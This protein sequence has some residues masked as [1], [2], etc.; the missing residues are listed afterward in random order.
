M[1]IFIKSLITLLC[2]ITLIALQAVPTY[3]SESPS[4]GLTASRAENISNS[5]P[6]S[7]GVYPVRLR[8]QRPAGSASPAGAA[9]TSS[10]HVYRSASADAG[11]EKISTQPVDRETGGLFIY[12]D[13]NPAAIPGK[14]YY[15]RVSPANSAGFSETV[16]GYG[17]LTPE[18][19]FKEYNKTVKVSHEKLTL[20]HK[21]GSMSKLG[22]E[23]KEGNISGSFSYNARVAGLGGR[24][25][26]TYERYADFY[27][28][29]N[30]RLGPYFVL[31]GNCNT[32][33][34]MSQNG[35]MDGTVTITGMYPGKI[36]Y[37]KVEIKN[38][39]AGGGT[40]GV[41]IQGF[42]RVELNWTV[43]EYK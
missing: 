41:E 11:F 16:M 13:E 9:G 29:N 21:A 4:Y 19:Y 24:V 20:M 1:C 8:W 42:P 26:M 3:A 31:N 27:I 38:G 28:E 32:S 5:K 15:Y 10:F 37:D 7:N 33:A 35:T 25:I 40:Y 22:S 12:I 30:S 18:S 14:Q 23:Q 2:L 6:N 43:G 36:Y 34:N 39:T 17:A